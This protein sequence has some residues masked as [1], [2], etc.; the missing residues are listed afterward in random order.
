M[1]PVLVER[2]K[3]DR[4]IKRK[5]KRNLCLKDDRIKNKTLAVIRI[6]NM[7]GLLSV[8]LLTKLPRRLSELM[9]YPEKS[10]ECSV[11]CQPDKKS[12]RCYQEKP[13]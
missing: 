4:I 7:K 10:L 5:V 8:E 1:H 11:L 2:I 13:E 9:Q 6:K 12:V 3:T